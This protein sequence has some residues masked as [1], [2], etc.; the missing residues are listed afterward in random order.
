[1]TDYQ[2][3]ALPLDDNRVPSMGAT[4]DNADPN[5]RTVMGVRIDPVTKRLL[6]DAQTSGYTANAVDDYTTSN[7]T[8]V[9]KEDNSGNWWI[10]KIDE[11]GNFPICTHAT[12]INNVTVTTYTDAYAARTSLTY[13]DY[14]DAF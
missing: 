5:K 6:V 2:N 8:Y 7:V 9:C 4:V 14:S 3:E 13:E 10:T 11:T 12:V 1:M